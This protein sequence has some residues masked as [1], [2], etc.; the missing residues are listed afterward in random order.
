MYGHSYTLDQKES[1]LQCHFCPFRRPL[2]HRAEA[3]LD[4]MLYEEMKR[5][6][7]EK[8]E[9]VIQ[10]AEMTRGKPEPKD[11]LGNLGSDGGNTW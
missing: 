11:Q 5:T 7:T 4:R 10:E 8:A 9:I 2:F 3:A 6:G 1:T